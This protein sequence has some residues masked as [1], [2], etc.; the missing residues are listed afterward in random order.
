MTH[1]SSLV[2]T[3]SRNVYERLRRSQCYKILESYKVSYPSGATKDAMIKIMEGSGIN[4]LKPGPYGEGVKYVQVQV[5]DEDGK[6][7]VEMYP[8]ERP[9]ATLN[10]AIN[11]DVEMEKILKER[12]AEEKV[13]DDRIAELEQQIQALMDKVG[14][15]VPVEVAEPVAE[16]TD[17]EAMEVEDLKALAKEKG[18]KVHHMAGK[19]KTI[20]ALKAG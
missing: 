17:Y 4:P 2:S 6:T 7:R 9:H 16:F 1:I 18:I 19:K 14:G 12:Q 8:E 20:E 11:Y 5:T 10:K 3:D 15:T 13:K